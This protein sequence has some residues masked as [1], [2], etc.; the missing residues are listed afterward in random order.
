MD[1]LAEHSLLGGFGSEVKGTPV[2]CACV[3]RAVQGPQQVGTDPVVAGVAIED[4]RR[5]R[6][7]QRAAA[8]GLAV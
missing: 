4:A 1:P 5:G 7:R 3:I 2:S 8:S 6:R